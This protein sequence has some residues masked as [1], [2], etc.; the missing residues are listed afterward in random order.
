MVRVEED[1]VKKRQEERENQT[2][3]DREENYRKHGENGGVRTEERDRPLDA[4]EKED[5]LFG[6]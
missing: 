4:G 2:Y 5:D 6:R 3:T 1:L